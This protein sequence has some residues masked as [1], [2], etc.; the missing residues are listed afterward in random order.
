MKH[1]K[2][3]FA[4]IFTLLLAAGVEVYAAKV[5]TPSSANSMSADKVYCTGATAT[6]ISFRYN[7]CNVGTG[8]SSG[9]SMTVNWYSNTTGLTSGGTLVFTETRN[10]RTR[11]TGTVRYTP[12]TATP[13]ENYYYAVITWSGSGTC[14]TSG[15]LTS[16]TA[17]KITVSESPSAISG[18]S[19]VCVGSTTT[20]T[21][22]ASGGTWSSSNVAKATVDL[23]TG[24]VT[25]VASGTANITYRVACGT[26]VTKVI[27]VS[28]TPTVAA[29]T[30]GTSN[31]CTGSTTTLS[32]STS[33]GTWSSAS[34]SIATINSVGVVTGVSP[35]IA[36]ISYQVST[37]CGTIYATKDVTVSTTPSAISGLS[38]SCTGYTLFY[39]NTTPY[40]TWTSSNTARATVDP[41]TGEIDALTAGAVTISYATG[42]GAT[43][44]K[45]LTI[46]AGP[47]AITGTTAICTGATSTLSNATGGGTWVSSNPT[48]ASIGS[49]T[50]IMTGVAAGTARITYATASACQAVITATVKAT[51]A[52]ISGAN[53]FCTGTTSTYTNTTLYGTWS[54]SNTSV[55]TIGSTTG[56]ATAVAAGTA[57]L[58]YTTGCGTAAT[59]VITVNTQPGAITGTASVCQGATTT[60]S[61]SVSGGV[62]TSESAAVA[63]VNA[64]G[65]VTG[66]AE[67]AVDITYTNG[68]C[69]SIKEVTVNPLAD[70]GTISGDLNVCDGDVTDLTT[71]G[72]AG[73][74]WTTSSSAIAT[75]DASGT[76]SGNAAG[77][78]RISYSVNNSCGTQRAIVVVTVDPAP[79]AGTI[80]GSSTV[81]EAASTTY[82]S[83][84]SGA[85]WSSSNTS[86]ATVGTGG[87][88]TG[89][90]GG[91]ATISY[92]STN[93][94]GTDMDTK[95]ITV[96]PLPAVASITGTGTVC[97]GATTTLSDLTSGGAWSSS[98][99]SVA[100]IGTSGVVTGVAA[101]TSNI[102][103]TVTNSCGT[104]YATTV[105]TVNP[106]ANAGTITG[107]ASMCALA[108]TTLSNAISGGVW[109][110]S[111]TSIATVSGGNVTG[112]AAGNATISYGVTNICGTQ[113]ATRAVT[114]NANPASITGT[115]TFCQLTTTTLSNATGSGTW[116][117]SNTSVA[118]IGSSTGVATGVAGG[119]AT[120]SYILSTGCYATTAVSVTPA[121]VVTVPSD[122]TV[123]NGATVPAQ[124]FSS[125]ISGTGY[126][127]TNSNTS[128]GLAA[129]NS[130][131]MCG[132]V[133][134]NGTLVMTAP[135]G[136]V[137]TGVTFASYGTPT[138][139][140][141]SFA[142]SSC[143]AVNSAAIVSSYLVGNSTA[144]IPARN[145]VFTDPCSG[146]FKRLYVQA[147]YSYSVVP[148]FTA[149]NPGATPLV[150]TVNVTPVANGCTGNSASYTI[151][152]D[153]TNAPVA[154]AMTG[155]GTY[156]SGGSGLAVGLANS[157]TGINYQLYKD[158]VSTGSPVAGTGSA[159]SFGVQTAVGTYSAQAT[160]TV[161]GCVNAMS[162][163]VT[164]SINPTPTV[165]V[166]ANQVVA[167]G[168]TQPALSLTGS[169]A[170]SV[171]SWTVDNSIGLADGTTGTICGTAS[172][173]GSV[174]LTAPAGS[175]FTS[176]DFASY[177]T[178]N[179]SC[180][181]F[182]I[183]G[184]NASTSTSV[185]ASYLIGNNSA[186]IPATNAV[187]G[188]PCVGTGKRLYIQ[189]SY[190]VIP[191]FTAV[192][193][194][195]APVVATVTV[196]PTKNGCVGT[197]GTFTITV[198][199]SVTTY[200]VTGGGSY[201]GTGAGVAVGLDGSQTGVNYQLKIGSTNV[202][203]AVAG[204]GSALSFG[205]F[206]VAGT[207]SVQAT[208]AA[209]GTTAAMTGSATITTGGTSAITG[210]LTVCEAATTTLSNATGGGAW[211]SS[212]TSVATVNSA[213]GVVTGVAAGN[214]TI[215][216]AIGSC[217]STAEVT[218]NPLPAAGTI[219]G[220]AVVCE[221][222]T[223][224]L[225]AS[226]GGGAWTSDN[227][228][229]ATV[230]GGT[231]TGVANGTATISYAVTNSCG[232][233]YATAVVTVNP[234]PAAGTI[235]GTAVVCEASTTNLSASVGGGAWT[236][237][238]TSVATVSGG[239]VTGVANGTAT[240][241]YAVTNSC[242]TDYATQAVTVNPL[243]A[244]GTISGTAVVCESSTTNL[245]AS[246]GGGAW[247]S[248]NTSVA[249]VSGGTVTGVANGT[250]TIS[251]AVTNSCGTDYA[252]AVVTVNPLPAAGTISGTAVV[253]EASTTNLSATIG[254]GAWTSDNTSVATV[255]G[256][257]VTGVASGTATISY[258]V[259]NS[260]GTDYATQAVTVNPL[261]AAGTISG[262]AVVCEVSTTSLSATIG[263]GAW[264]SDNT[265]VATVSGGT[266]TGV[267]NGTA[268][269]S[270]AVTNSCG[271]DYTTQVVT[272]NPLPA[273]GT[274]SG[275]ANVCVGS[276][277]SLSASVGGGAWTTSDASVATV[278]GG[279]VTGV[280]SGN[281]TISYAVTNSCGT[282]YATHAVTAIAVP[283]VG[284]TTGATVICAGSTSDLDNSVSGG[285]WTSSD[286]TV[287]TVDGTG[288]VTGV[289]A[290]TASI[291][292]ANTNSCGTAEDM[293]TVTVNA[294]SAAITG[295]NTL[296]LGGT[297]T[298]T[299]SDAAGTWSSSNVAAAT[300]NASTGVI[301]ST[302]LGTTV[303]TYTAATGCFY[304]TKTLTVNSTVANITGTK[305]ACVG[306]TSALATATTGGAWSSSNTAI[307][308]VD[309][310]TG[311][312]TAV[313]AGT[314]MISY[315]ISGGCYN[316]DMFISNAMPD[317]ITG[318]ASIC[319]EGYTALASTVGGAGVWSSSNTSVAVINSV[320]GL[321]EGVGAGNSTI[322]YH[323]PATGCEVTRE[324][325][326][327]AS[328]AAIAGVT[329]ICA[330]STVAFSNAT[331]GGTWSSAQPWV[332]S[333][334][335]ATG[336]VTTITAGGATISYTASNGCYRT[337]AVTVNPL[338]AGIT[339]ANWNV[340]LG[341]G[342][343]LA[344]TTTG[345]TW[346][347]GN[348]SVATIG[349]ANG[350]VTSQGIGSA[351]ITY[352]AATGCT[353]T[354]TVS[355]Y[356]AT[357][358]T[359]G[360]DMIC[361][362]N[363]AT[364]TN[365]TA[366]GTWISGNTTIATINWYT[367]VASTGVMGGTVNIS[368]RL[369]S[370]GCIALKQVTVA[371]ITGN[372][373]VCMGST[374]TL[375]HAMTGGTWASSNTARA[376]VDA[377][378]GEVAAVSTG[379]AII[380][381]FVSPTV[382]T[383][384][385]IVVNP[386]PAAISGASALCEGLYTGYTGNI[387]GSGTWSSSDVAVGS[388]Y[389]IDGLF[390]ALSAGTTTL[391]YKIPSTGCYTTRTV[392]VNPAPAPISG[393][394]TVCVGE[395]ATLSSTADGG[396]WTKNNTLV[397]LNAST[398]ELTGVSG[399]GVMITYTSPNGCRRYKAMTVNATPAA[400]SGST[401][402]TAG[403]STT[404]TS[405]SSGGTWSSSD[406]SVANPA[407]VM[408][409]GASSCGIIHGLAAGSATISYTFANGC[410]RTANVTVSS[411][412]PGSVIVTESTPIVSSFKLYPNPTS[413][414][415]NVESSVAGKL[416]VYTIDGKVAG[417]YSLTE[418]VTSVTL[419]SGLASGVY[420]CQ[421]SFN[422]GTAKAERLY[423][424]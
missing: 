163:S 88:V 243:P 66:V 152:I 358:P 121:P 362:G 303:I 123:C 23:T 322:T 61:N 353:R 323:I 3:Q 85:V 241:S 329:P 77:T 82:T 169:L 212:N 327:N 387:G 215:T 56:I 361:K 27:T 62:W 195:A 385:I 291:T 78:A 341:V 91:N 139:S 394:P 295:A 292:Y 89:V 316:T 184:C 7:T 296:C 342:T 307:A 185:A 98:N 273:A 28:T 335:S 171:Y 87:V 166:P 237:D 35:G 189:A 46:N 38:T 51:P 4:L 109:S 111:N 421:F 364:Y 58:T 321:L 383:T 390:T 268:T 233:D 366:G 223:T 42:C 363:S 271:T 288:L 337:Y 287:A 217:T 208:T 370:N 255:S 284:S 13:G 79:D 65:V 227:T 352:T 275:S 286:A 279:T 72:D 80:S 399:G 11:S 276:T 311:V 158:G 259:T 422:D 247:T 199:P 239:T 161:T 130:G 1:L 39:T 99:T 205:T 112:V 277:S 297:T 52:S 336:D 206:T 376:T 283:T 360:P 328:P 53:A 409:I 417:E 100:T 309:A 249:T 256:G 172:E 193:S 24:E 219:S 389:Y 76:V 33:G 240:I 349:S 299:I 31:V 49:S 225:S 14:N 180:G 177:G 381:Y 404:L 94:C 125:S 231:V 174:T 118:T 131:S 84:V 338:P 16:A 236:S 400:I 154:Y 414:T 83:T 29:I 15:T 298:F 107:T 410:A 306:F 75:V 304:S 354:A 45:T 302:G 244:A 162:G 272:V 234:L 106:L 388:I 25:G 246:V 126:S 312:V 124:S 48:V 262:T 365:A 252:T 64:S 377:S 401:S 168:A 207:Y 290:G 250:A 55:A 36:T 108:G 147:T 97:V 120:I 308:T 181:S 415:F 371:A 96:N 375:S 339:S 282:D 164:V 334:D 12:S 392:T 413:G 187:F 198:D 175:V 129:N 150:G 157:T 151:T 63:S 176:I 68:V 267:A 228:S 372:T 368:Y 346:M 238:N 156:C 194:G 257:T 40:G 235:S 229:V 34:T 116:S 183:G 258:A 344:S 386:L 347:S 145:S 197:P 22:T 74:S 160:N 373:R 81:C 196:T 226:V 41:A 260:C 220:T 101:G 315:T 37:S 369:T 310:S 213:T 254:G 170:G 408:G 114:V 222:S 43:V 348:T 242:G 201:C 188:D 119:N 232:T 17:T 318:T 186:T 141:G 274:V 128:I 403:A 192:N 191:S 224:N 209:V 397:S 50:G 416:V 5:Y 396:V 412:K 93:G 221:S 190:G 384:A 73:G 314:A 153:N 10:C 405:M 6:R 133:S 301:T 71:D 317:P 155:G 95:V 420:M 211:T 391:T 269:I 261:P 200:N 424:K 300:V 265:S 203:S 59:K 398:G 54:S 149:T 32:N 144:S 359:V 270:Y 313:S 374:T 165:T 143:H 230:S 281:A 330:E 142:T 356:S 419:S 137:F 253:C 320:S 20:L 138:G 264:T 406:C 69:R 2:L 44:T 113:Y 202:G 102:T 57:R 305:Y 122:M 423:V 411:A 210:T 345:G 70:P 47:T 136:A 26:R 140:C 380:T 326:I 110:S 30:G 132:T 324:V 382:Y 218:V 343:T 67:G 351:P 393:S 178:P 117:S 167:N 379:T 92:V 135:T 103:Y 159:I 378:S 90:A 19:T 148:S 340:C 285:A 60:L 8:G 105:V 18:S 216:Y 325:T 293:V 280:A 214:A 9:T 294:S 355:V 278:S 266:V 146:T 173:G 350:V 251:Y 333:I 179:G 134:E 289:A 331:T 115:T 104:T 357:A 248:D 127:W 395:S 402:I 86:V 204:T 182:T 332:A 263:G 418:G 319:T 21:N 245:S 407:T 367:G